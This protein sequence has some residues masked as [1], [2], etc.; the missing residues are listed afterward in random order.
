MFVAKLARQLMNRDSYDERKYDRHL[1]RQGYAVTTRHEIGCVNFFL[2]Y[3]GEQRF[4]LKTE[5]WM[6][7]FDRDITLLMMAVDLDT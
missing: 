3:E 2:I 7:A 5:Q 6:S 4:S 1:L